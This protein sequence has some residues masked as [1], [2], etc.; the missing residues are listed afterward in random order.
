MSVKVAPSLHQIQCRMGQAIMRPLA[1]DGMQKTWLDDAGMH[2]FA[3]EFIKPNKNMSSFER[4]EIYNKQYWFRL[5]DSLQEDFPGLNAI[6]GDERFEA[7]CVAY[8]TAYPS[9]S[10][11]LNHLGA[12]LARFIRDN[13]EFTHPCSSMAYQATSMEWAEIVAYDADAKTP[14]AQKSLKNADPEK[15]V[16]R[17][18]PH[19]TILEL[20]YAIDNF[21][22]Q[23][24]KST[25]KSVESNAFIIRKKKDIKITRPRRQHIFVAV[26]RLNNTVYYKRL[27]RDQYFLLRSFSEGKSIA[28]ACRDLVDRLDKKNS[29]E[30]TTLARK[31]NEYFATWMELN[32]FCN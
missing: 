7:L 4:L 22:L 19:I 18:Q 12:G 31:L 26:H 6:L 32:W 27:N 13:P 25:D 3:A 30:A 9:R 11:S 21:L 8:L 15:I 1:E 10:Y 24:N 14:L 16:L 28:Q 5:L 20:D 17:L 2:D 29:A 23:L